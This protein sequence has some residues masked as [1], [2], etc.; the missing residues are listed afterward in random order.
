MNA[1]PYAIY[2][3]ALLG[4]ETLLAEFTARRPMLA[5]LLD[6]LRSNQ[7]GHPPQHLLLI[8]PWGMGKTTLL[9]ALAHT[10]ADKDKNLK[11]AFQPVVFD[12]ESRRVGDLTDFWLECIRQWEFATHAVTRH[13]EDLLDHPDEKIEERARE[14]F[15]EL[16][17]NSGKRAILLIDNLNEMLSGIGDPGA[18]HRLRAFLMESDQVTVIGTATRWFEE[19]T[20][21]TNLSS[22]FS[23]P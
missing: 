1:R 19:V 6:I 12:E 18:M 7:P 8:G 9:W 21:W 22:T 5:R 2:N 23:A 16:V 17:A 4:S 15:L 3:P 20:D 11:R 10:V 13:A 14:R